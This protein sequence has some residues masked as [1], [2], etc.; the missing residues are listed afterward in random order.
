MKLWHCR[1]ARSLRALWALEEM[2]LDYDVH[3]MPF[4]P[5]IFEQEYL[6][7]NPLG[8]VPYFEDGDVRMTES[9][10]ICLYLVEKYARHDLGLQ[11]D[12]PEYGDYLNWLFHSDATLTFPQTIAMRY[13][14]LEPTPEKQEVG[15]DYMKW[16]FA[17]L[18]LL[19]AHLE[20]R[21]YLCDNRFT[22]A[23]IAVGYAIYLAKQMKLTELVDRQFTPQ[24]EAWYERLVERP[25]FMRADAMDGGQPPTLPE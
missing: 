15:V 18:K 17:R 16:F 2:G 9:T 13:F 7:T 1:G 4:P 12:H 6:Q 10:G 24:V 22:V 25:A 19:N 21:D 8:T 20:N 11:V 3:V 5:R 14:H 23:D